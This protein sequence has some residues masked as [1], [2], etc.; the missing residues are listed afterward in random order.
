MATPTEANGSPGP[1]AAGTSPPA[2]QA[3]QATTLEEKPEDVTQPPVEL[4]F[5]R[6][7]RPGPVLSELWRSRELVRTLAERELRAR[8]KQTVLGFAWA[9]ITPVTLMLVFTIFLKRV[10]RIDTGGAPYALYVYVG[11]IPWTLFSSS[12]SSSSQSLISNLSLLNKVYC[13]REVFPLGS[14]VVSALDSMVATSVLGVLFVVHQYA[15]TVDSFYALPVLLVVQAMFT[16]GIALIV[17][18]TT[19]YLRDLRQALPM[20]LQLALFATPVAYGIDALPRSVQPVYSALNPLAPV[21]DGY[22]R[23]V[24]L[25]SPPDWP[26]IAIAALSAFCVL[27]GG[28]VLFKRLE[29]TIADVA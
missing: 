17:S 6:R 8:Y 1:T 19:V 12:V 21:I 3:R 16:I 9:I 25:G 14:V 24:L 28:A 4:R 27:V 23:S 20:L 13:P 11:L 2:D 10:A 18:V 5:R 26:L 29:T 7:L 22:R 15:P